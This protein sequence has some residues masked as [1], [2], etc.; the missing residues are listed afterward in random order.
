MREL[1]GLKLWILENKS[2]DGMLKVEEVR[3]ELGG[4]IAEYMEQLNP[5][6]AAIKKREAALIVQIESRDGQI[7]ELEKKKRVNE[8]Q[9]LAQLALQVQQ[10]KEESDSASAVQSEK[11]KT[12]LDL[13]ETCKTQTVTEKE[14][15]EIITSLENQVSVLFIVSCFK[16]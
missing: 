15:L 8:D 1:D 11:D 5:K 13:Q 9:H 14:T 10:A 7:A 12:I 2:E 16:V 4:W 6:Q 3:A